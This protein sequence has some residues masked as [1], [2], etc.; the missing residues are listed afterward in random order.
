M[1]LAALVPIVAAIQATIKVAPARPV[2]RVCVT[3]GCLL[4]PRDRRC[5][6]CDAKAGCYFARKVG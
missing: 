3:C 6:G 4:L 2:R 5:P 1:L